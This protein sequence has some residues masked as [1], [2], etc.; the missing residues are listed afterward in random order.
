MDKKQIADVS[1]S[2]AS[3]QH[4]HNTKGVSVSTNT[5][6]SDKIDTEKPPQAIG[7]FDP[8]EIDTEATSDSILDLTSTPTAVSHTLTTTEPS[9]LTPI[10][11]LN[12]TMANSGGG[13][14]A[15]ANTGNMGL[16]GVPPK[17]T[18]LDARYTVNDFIRAF[19]RFLEFKGLA[20]MQKKP[21]FRLLLDD[22]AARYYYSLQVTAAFR[23][24]YRLATVPRLE[25]VAALWQ[26]TQKK[27]EKVMD[28]IDWVKHKGQELQLGNEEIKSIVLKGIYPA[29]RSF[30]LQGNYDTIEEI[31]D[32]AKKAEQGMSVEIPQDM[33]TMMVYGDDDL[34]LGISQ[35]NLEERERDRR[36][37]FQDP[38]NAWSRGRR[39]EQRGGYNS[40]QT[41]AGTSRPGSRSSGFGN[42]PQ[43]GQ[44]VGYRSASPMRRGGF[45]SP[46]TMNKGFGYRATSPR[47][48]ATQWGPSDGRSYSTGAMKTCG[49][50]G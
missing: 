41:G 33:L 5:L 39:M 24:R 25:L 14:P 9:N 42:T 17:F 2:I 26:R 20:D 35:A 36:V 10:D 1:K 46:N 12:I 13:S 8:L 11:T 29:I 18:G 21:T 47:R 7:G 44:G 43:S 49:Q 30:V 34:T 38:P 31:T 32:T 45:G 19:N 48:Y 50:C 16:L 4:P 22:G 28:Y 15:A 3:S 6:V 40:Y 23:K 37:R 27:E